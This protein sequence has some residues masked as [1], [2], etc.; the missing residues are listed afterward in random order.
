MLVI[1]MLFLFTASTV[2]QNSSIQRSHSLQPFSKPATTSIPTTG[3]LNVV[4]VMVEFQPDSNELT[5]GI[6]TF[7][8]GGIPY[9]ES[10]PTNIDPLPHNQSYFE[11]HLAFAA[12][13]FNRVSDGQLSINYQ[14]LPQVYTLD[15]KMEEYS[16]TGETFTYHKLAQLTLDTWNAVEAEGG[17]DATG[18]DPDETAFIIFHAGVGRDIELIGTSLDITP[19]DIPS[20]TLRKEDLGQLFDDPNFEGIPVN[21]GSFRITNSLILPRTESRRGEDIQ[22]NEVV[23]PLSINGL[24]CASIGSHL[25]LPDLF[26]IENGESGIGRFGL[27]DG[28]SIFAYNGLFPPAPSAWEKTYLGWE[29]PFL[30]NT[31][32]PNPIS[33]PAASLAQPN[34]IAKLELSSSEYFLVENRHRD[35]EEDGVVITIQKPSGAIIQQSFTNQNEDFVFQTSEFDAQFESGVVID[36]DNFDWALPGGLDIGS[37]NEAGTAD[38]RNLNGGILIW[39]IDEAVLNTNLAQDLGVNQNDSRRGVDLEEADG[40]QDIGK[41]LDGALDNSAAFGSPF[42]FWWDGNDARVVNQGNTIQ[43]YKNEFSRTSTPSNASNTGAIQPFKLTNFSENQAIATFHI[44]E[45]NLDDLLYTHLEL[46]QIDANFRAKRSLHTES[47]PLSVSLYITQTDSFLVLNSTSSIELL[48]LNDV[49][50]EVY[51]IPIGSTQQVLTGQQL[52]VAQDPSLFSPISIS[53]YDWNPI[54]P[55]FDEVWTNTSAPNFGFMSSQNGDSL[56]LDFTSNAFDFNDGSI[57]SNSVSPTFKSEV[58]QNEYAFIQGPEVRFSSPAL[59]TYLHNGINR[60]YVGTIKTNGSNFYYIL[61]DERLTL[62]NPLLS[63]PFVSIFESDTINWP[64]ISEDLEFFLVDQQSNALI[65]INKNG[66]ILDHFPITAPKT[67]KF[68][69]TPLLADLNGDNEQELLV[70]ATD[71]YSLNILAYSKSGD[72]LEGFPL[73]VGEINSKQTPLH[74][75]IVDNT[76]YAISEDGDIKGWEFTSLTTSEWSSMYGKNRFNKVSATATISD[77]PSTV[78]NVLNKAETYNWPNPANEFTHI[79]YETKD[80]GEV[81]INIINQTGQRVF[82]QKIKTLGGAPEEIEINTSS[83]GNGAYYAMVQATVNGKKESKL[84]K[85][86]VIH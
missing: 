50:Q 26:N 83:W 60:N 69:G 55:S 58:H 28:A 32:T 25:G 24:L 23:L 27:M 52:I 62:V 70:T 67:F 20:I 59:P 68:T 64:A 54:T 71:D 78:F 30:I 33:L 36:V 40:S 29:T 61:T 75:I 85:I 82:S 74:P 6:G 46:P 12:N 65:G 7:G 1:G 21:G 16:P 10:S 49:N 31:S 80:M 35:P 18:L 63:D 84:I 37:D 39:H 42:D 43:L 8:P 79:R 15:K 11:A 47:Y 2:G 9:L 13:Y 81:E 34:S 44:E 45:Q 76:L 48:H 73:Y 19:Q 86:A 72:M 38:D 22:E 17:F 53:A 4:A 3:T 77:E 57:L 5:S 41:P 56:F 14:V 66:A 51:S